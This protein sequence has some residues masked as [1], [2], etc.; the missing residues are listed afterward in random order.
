M[1]PAEQVHTTRRQ[2]EKQ[3]IWAAWPPSAPNSAGLGRLFTP[4]SSNLAHLKRSERT[5]LV[6]ARTALLDEFSARM[7]FQQ[8]AGVAQA[9]PWFPGTGNRPAMPLDPLAGTHSAAERFCS[10]RICSR[11]ERR[12]GHASDMRSGTLIARRMCVS[13]RPVLVAES[14]NV[15]GYV[16]DGATQRWENP[17]HKK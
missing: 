2:S 17:H 7:S 3:P 15:A 9:M 4:C 5:M 12:S 6:R 16:F 10:E 14:P 8:V 1:A 13:V 11:T